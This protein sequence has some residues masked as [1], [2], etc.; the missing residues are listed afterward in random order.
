MIF[1]PYSKLPIWLHGGLT[2][3]WHAEGWISTAGPFDTD[4][5]LHVGKIE[6][7]GGDPQATM[8]RDGDIHNLDLVGLTTLPLH[9]GFYNL[10]AIKLIARGP[11]VRLPRSCCMTVNSMRWRSPNLRAMSLI[12]GK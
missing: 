12:S 8:R 11:P 4:W 7:K 2:G 5:H 1:L 6:A 10:E 3:R 9:L